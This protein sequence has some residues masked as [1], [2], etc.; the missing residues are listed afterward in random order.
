MA[1][2]IHDTSAWLLEAEQRAK[3]MD[4]HDQGG[5]AELFNILGKWKP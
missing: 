3:S 4:M 1:N 5:P 2:D